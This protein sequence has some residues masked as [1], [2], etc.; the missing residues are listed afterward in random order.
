MSLPCRCKEPK[1]DYV[2]NTIMFCK[3]CFRVVCNPKDPKEKI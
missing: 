1:I 2:K 3:G